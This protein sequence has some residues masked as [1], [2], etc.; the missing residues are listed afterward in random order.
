[1]P[2]Q[3][4][5]YWIKLR[6]DF[7]DLPTIDWLME[8]E[9]GCNYVVLYQKLC[10]M[11][12][13]Q[14]GA[15][16]RRIGEMIIP[17]EPKKIAEITKF[18]ISTVRVALEL[19][20]R[21]GLIYING[22]GIM[23]LDGVDTMVG[24]ES[25]NAGAQRQRRLRERRKKAEI[26]PPSQDPGGGPESESLRNVTHEV[27]QEVTDTVADCVTESVTRSVT[28]SNEEYRDK[29]LEIEGE[30]EQK[31]KKRAAVAA[32]PTPDFSGTTFSEEMREKVQEWISYKRQ[33]G[34]KHEYQEIGLRNLISEIQ[35]N[36]EKYGEKAV[37][38][39]IRHCMAA[40]YQGIIFDRLK[41]MPMLET[42]WPTENPT[43]PETNNEFARMRQRLEAERNG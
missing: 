17:Y 34:P 16:V 19:Y 7:F 36:V 8:Q 26:P 31:K 12:A 18:S 24:S 41:G 39:L 9:D 38:D 5:Y 6:T 23:I 3:K 33:K 35:H 11:T 10:L 43:M 1:M 2:D 13:N 28:E 29:R 40:N 14:G 42:S 37:I 22:D 20:K 30:Q 25:A 32:P 21:L 27:T 4:R 15:L